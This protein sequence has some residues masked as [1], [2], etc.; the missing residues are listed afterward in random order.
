MSNILNAMK[1]K[2]SSSMEAFSRDLSR[3]RTGRASLSLL[4]GVKIDA[5]GSHLPLSQVAGMTIPESRMI[6]I[7]PWDLQLINHIEKAILKSNLGLN[8][9]S[10]GKVIRI[11]F[12]QLTGERRKELVKQVKKLGED[13]RVNVRNHRREVIDILKKQKKDKEITEDE[14]FKLQDE[15]QKETDKYIKKIDEM[16]IEKEK[17]VMEV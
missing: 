13:Y 17:E 2:L 9:A 7:Q 4:D 14:L 15:T 11:S 10:D 3:V 1:D 8:P 16:L 5:Y 12:P 6:V